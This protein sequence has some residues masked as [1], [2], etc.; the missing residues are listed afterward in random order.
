HVASLNIVTLYRPYVN[1]GD[2]IQHVTTHIA[3]KL[4]LCHVLTDHSLDPDEIAR[5]IF[6]H[7]NAPATAGNDEIS[8]AHQKTDLVELDNRLGLRRR[9]HPAPAAP[10]VLAHGPALLSR[11][12][13][14]RRLLH[15]RA[16]RLGE[17]GECRI[18]PS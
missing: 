11:D 8:R 1:P 6:H 3:C 10:G 14:S 13:L 4:T 7:R 9:H 15:V 12:A 18:V 5:G 16:N 17:I 2:H